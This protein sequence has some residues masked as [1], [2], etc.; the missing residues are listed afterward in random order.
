MA[1]PV[2][3]FEQRLSSFNGSFKFTVMLNAHFSRHSTALLT[4]LALFV[5]RPLAVINALGRH[6]R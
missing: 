6:F 2:F 5:S 1:F 3:C 4:L